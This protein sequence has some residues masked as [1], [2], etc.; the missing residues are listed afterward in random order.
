M[1]KVIQVGPAQIVLQESAGVASAVISIDQSV[2]GGQ[3]AGVLKA[4][5]S[6]E[7]DFGAQ[8]AADLVIG[9]LEMK[10]PAAAGLLEAAKAAL[11]AEL[12]K[13]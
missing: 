10:F 13:L 8:Q 7:L 12:Q 6:I 4:K 5:A 2:G 9:L 1:Q 11:D 3:A